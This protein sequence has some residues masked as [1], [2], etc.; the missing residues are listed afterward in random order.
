MKVTG[1]PSHTGLAEAEIEMLTGSSGLTIIVTGDEVAGLSAEQVASDVS[2][3]VTASLF[4]GVIENV[5]LLL[6]VAMPF[7]FH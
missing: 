2:T 3:H 6:P 1:V 4:A 5:G 7:T